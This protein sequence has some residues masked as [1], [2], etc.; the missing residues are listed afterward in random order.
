MRTIK[1]EKL[2]TVSASVAMTAA[3]VLMVGLFIKNR[4]ASNNGKTRE[5]NTFAK[6]SRFVSLPA[7]DFGRSTATLVIFLSSQCDHCTNS[8]P[9]YKKLVESQREGKERITIVGVF[10]EGEAGVT[11]L[12]PKK[13]PNFGC[14]DSFGL[15]GA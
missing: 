4:G 11:E 6:G 14:G 13:W 9:F 10:P 7:L 3:F 8:T 2:L 15:Q 12:P 5:G 1:L